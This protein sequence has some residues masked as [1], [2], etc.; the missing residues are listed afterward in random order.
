MPLVRRLGISRV[1]RLVLGLAHLEKSAVPAVTAYA[2][3]YANTLAEG[4]ESKIQYPHRIILR[5]RQ[6][7]VAE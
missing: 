3:L 4:Y 2:N 1:F 6:K 5:D 7:A